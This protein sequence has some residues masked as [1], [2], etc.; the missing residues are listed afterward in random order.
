[1]LSELIASQAQILQNPGDPDFVNLTHYIGTLLGKC[2]WGIPISCLRHGGAF[3]IQGGR[4]AIPEG[5]KAQIT[6]PDW[7]NTFL[8]FDMLLV[9]TLKNGQQKITSC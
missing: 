9:I 7:P 6:I 1:M 8:G 5:E 2:Q 3:A 4:L